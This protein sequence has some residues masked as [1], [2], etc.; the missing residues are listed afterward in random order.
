[1][2]LK[3]LTTCNSSCKENKS[4]GVLRK[5]NIVRSQSSIQKT[6]L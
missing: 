2:K 6:K 4:Y 5:S 1:M 3:Y